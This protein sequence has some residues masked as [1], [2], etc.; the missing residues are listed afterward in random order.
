MDHPLALR[1]FKS[2]HDCCTLPLVPGW[3]HD[4]HHWGDHRG[5]C[6]RLH[7]HSPDE[8]QAAQ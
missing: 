5:L 4:H 8:V 7:L 3:Y 6:P 1:Y 2:A